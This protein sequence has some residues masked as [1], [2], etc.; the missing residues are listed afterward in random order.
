MDFISISNS[1]DVFN[2]DA[3]STLTQAVKMMEPKAAIMQ[4]AFTSY[5]ANKGNPVEKMRQALES[6]LAPD[7]VGFGRQAIADP[8]TLQKLRKGLFDEINW[9]MRC[10]SCFRQKHCKHYGEQENGAEG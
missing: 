10:N 1:P 2:A 6:R 8:M 4:A 5:L 3:I 7:F 9:C